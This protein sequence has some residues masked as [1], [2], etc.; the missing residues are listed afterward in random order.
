M[1]M[2]VQPM[3][4]SPLKLLLSQLQVR[5]RQTRTK[6]HVKQKDIPDRLR[7]AAGSTTKPKDLFEKNR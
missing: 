1:L 4:M 5:P 7:I 2:G 6:T 3:A